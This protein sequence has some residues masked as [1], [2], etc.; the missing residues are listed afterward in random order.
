M[1]ESRCMHD[2]QVGE[3]YEAF[4]LDAL[5]LVQHAGLN[6]MGKKCRAGCPVGNLQAT[7]DDLTAAGI[8]VAV[9]EEASPLA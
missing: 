6:P 9:Y 4:G 5:M 3:F 2:L 7:L 1:H 8:T